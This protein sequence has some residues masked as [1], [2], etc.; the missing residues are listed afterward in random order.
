MIVRQ[1][2]IK[3]KYQHVLFWTEEPCKF[4][5]LL[6]LI[7][8]I[9]QEQEGSQEKPSEEHPYNDSSEPV[10]H[11]YETRCH[12]DPGEEERDKAEKAGP[13]TRGEFHEND[14]CHTGSTHCST[15]C[16]KWL[17]CKSGKMVNGSPNVAEVFC[18]L[19]MLFFWLDCSLYLLWS[20]SSSPVDCGGIAC[21]IW[22]I[23]SLC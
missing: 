23:Q 4:K 15:I 14:G 20:P 13:E 9:I 5:T 22:S 10:R 12:I 21:R 7:L 2:P 8:Q 6:V 19:F 11:C 1:L 18:L 16:V 17:V 3:T